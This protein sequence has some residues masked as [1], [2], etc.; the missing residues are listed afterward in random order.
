MLRF[1]VTTTN[2]TGSDS[3][4]HTQQQFSLQAA[5]TLA[6]TGPH[7]DVNFEIMPSQLAGEKSSQDAFNSLQTNVAGADFI[8]V[9]LL[10]L[11]LNVMVQLT[12][13]ACN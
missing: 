6:T 8:H 12:L 10:L 3:E 2:I 4:A 1:A 11:F 7:R 9:S 5:S 13:L